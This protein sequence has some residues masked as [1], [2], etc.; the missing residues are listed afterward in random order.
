MIEPLFDNFAACGHCGGDHDGLMTAPLSE[1]LKQEQPGGGTV[2]FTRVAQCPKT[3]KLIFIN[4]PVPWAPS[5]GEAGW[6]PQH[7]PRTE[8]A[9]GA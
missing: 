2:L 3:M 1:P 5:E 6:G 9:A 8:T 4:W 7:V